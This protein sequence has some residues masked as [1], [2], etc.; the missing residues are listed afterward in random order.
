M[1]PALIDTPF[2][3]PAWRLHRVIEL[4]SHRPSTLQPGRNDD[5]YVRRYRRIALA[6]TAA[7]TD[8][9]KRAAVFR[10]YPAVCHA[11]QIYYSRD[12]EPRQVLE[13]RLLTRETPEEIAI[14]FATTPEAIDYYEKL[15]FDVRD[16][17]ECGDW[18][19][20]IVVG[21]RD[22]YRG[23]KTGNMTSAD[24]GYV[25][26][27]FAYAGGPLALDA[28][29]R[30]LILKTPPQRIEDVSPWFDDAL[31]QLVQ[32][33]A[34]AAATTLQLNRKNMLQLMKLAIR[35]NATAAAAQEER[36]GTELEAVAKRII[37]RLHLGV[38]ER[39][40]PNMN[41][42]QR[43]FCLSAVEPRA[44]EQIDLAK[45]IVPESLLDRCPET[46]H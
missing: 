39:E 43:K 21:S 28:V 40:L 29:V 18:I 10:E 26:K 30:G 45:G 35:T 13:A 46:T 33:S 15:F 37:K 27:L 38:L 11:H 25:L 8:E 24:R 20:R 12:V 5:H 7:G 4:V 32:T 1:N 16:R 22:E 9:A 6:L 19:H 2:R 34:A 3:H 44:S 36:E 23:K 14:R 41:E 42:H 17:L 31:N